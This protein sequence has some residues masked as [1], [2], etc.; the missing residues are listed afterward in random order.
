MAR[1]GAYCI[2]RYEACLIRRAAD[3]RDTLHSPYARPAKGETYVAR[4]SANVVPQA[5]LHRHEAQAACENAGKRLCSLAEWYGACAGE[6][7]LTYP[8]GPEEKPGYCNTGRPHML[9]RLFGRDPRRWSYGEHFNSPQ[10]NREPGG[11]ARTG[12]H[13]HCVAEPG[14]YDLVG[15]LH[16]WISDRVDY[17]L[18]KK[19]QLNGDIQAKIPDNYGKAIFMG[20]F[21]STTDQHGPGCRFLTPGHGPQ[22]HDYST[23]FRCCADARDADGVVTE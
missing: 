12:A 17:E 22:Y 20:G 21:Y 14:V 18:P 1:R 16:E 10:L 13:P 19:I 11:L 6:Q 2:D 4:S 3:G 9:A 15:N 8:Y 7:K 23:G 5:Y